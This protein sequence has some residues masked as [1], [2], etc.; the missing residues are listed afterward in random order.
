MLDLFQIVVLLRYPTELQ[1][2]C[3]FLHE[4]SPKKKT[5]RVFFKSLRLCHT[6]SCWRRVSQFTVT[7][8]EACEYSV[9][10]RQLLVDFFWSLRSKNPACLNVFPLGPQSEEEDGTRAQ[11]QNQGVSSCCLLHC[12]NLLCWILTMMITWNSVD[13]Q[14]PQIVLPVSRFPVC[15]VKTERWG[16]HFIHLIGFS[17]QGISLIITF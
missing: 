13:L 8:L 10:H 12:L 11:E 15:I 4:C 14:V 3:L 17:S 16:N 9:F 5:Q 1:R 7:S 6:G 2:L